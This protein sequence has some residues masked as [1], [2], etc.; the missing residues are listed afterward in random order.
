MLPLKPIDTKITVRRARASDLLAADA[1]IRSFAARGELLPR[2]AEEL[3]LLL[4][5]AF[6]AVVDEA[7]TGF[8]ALEIY[9]RKL[10]EIQCLSFE[11]TPRAGEIIR[12][13]VEHCVQRAREQAVLEVMT[14]VAAPLEEVLKAC[15]FDYALPHQKRAMFVRP[16]LVDPRL[17]TNPPSKVT[18][19][20]AA[21]HD[22]PAVVEFLAPF[23]ARR[24]VLRRSQKELS[25]LLTGGFLARA[26]GHIVGFVALEIYS[27]KLAEIQCLSVDEAYRGQGIGHRL[28][29]RCVQRAREYH[30][31]EA[32]AISAHEELLQSCGF[33]FCLPGPKTALFFRTREE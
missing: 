22:L 31:T 20:V 19:D 24:E 15:G 6:V 29:M 27:E 14:V 8:A 13:L 10:S 12:E 32:M 18:I 5:H 11:A 28:I 4:P 1:L 16:Q 7:V 3:A 21:I 25:R 23:V 33:D 17:S 9:S 26:E 2:T 30:V